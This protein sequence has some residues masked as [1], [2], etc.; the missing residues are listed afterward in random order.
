[1]LISQKSS[2]FGSKWAINETEITSTVADFKRKGLANFIAKS[3]LKFTFHAFGSIIECV[4]IK[5]IK[6]HSINAI[7]TF[8]YCMI[9]AC[10]E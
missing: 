1:M 9:D 10:S 4:D 7:S 2:L 6:T 8:G 5:I 3:M